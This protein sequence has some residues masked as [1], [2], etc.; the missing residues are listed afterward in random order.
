MVVANTLVLSCGFPG[1]GKDKNDVNSRP[2]FEDCIPEHE[3]DF[4]ST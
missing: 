2:K 4:L 3:T 1:N